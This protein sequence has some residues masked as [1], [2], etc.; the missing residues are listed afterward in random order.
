MSKLEYDGLTQC[1]RGFQE[2]ED[3][4]VRVSMPDATFQRHLNAYLESRGL[5]TQTYTELMGYVQQVCEQRV[6]AGEHLSNLEYW[7]ECNDPEVR[8]YQYT[9]PPRVEPEQG[10][11]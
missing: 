9:F 11:H 5:P 2:D 10:H 7:R 8:V 6:Q 3:G 4:F 1:W